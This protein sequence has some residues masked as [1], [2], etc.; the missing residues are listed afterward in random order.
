MSLQK[1]L[2][3]DTLSKTEETHLA[4]LFSNVTVKKYLKILAQNELSELASLDPMVVSNEDL[5]KAQATIH[6]ALNVINTLSILSDRVQQETTKP[7]TNS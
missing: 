5:V 1:L 7:A 2:E 6:G 4:T 3:Q